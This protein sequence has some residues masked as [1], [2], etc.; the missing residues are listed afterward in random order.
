[1]LAE[2][3]AGNIPKVARRPL[4]PRRRKPREAPPPVAKYQSKADIVLADLL[5]RGASSDFFGSL[6]GH[7]AEHLIADEASL[8]CDSTFAGSVEERNALN[9]AD[10]YGDFVRNLS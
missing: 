3:E 10:A 7:V 8:A 9:A 4:K 1:M 2:L 6:H 5:A